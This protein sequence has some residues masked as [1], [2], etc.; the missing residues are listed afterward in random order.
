MVAW[1]ILG[2]LRRLAVPAERERVFSGDYM[3]QKKPPTRPSVIIGLVLLP[4]AWAE[5]SDAQTAYFKGKTIT[6]VQGRDPGGQG[7]MR[8]RALIAVLQKHIPGNPAIVSEYM[9]GG[10]GRKAANHMFR[11]ARPDGFTIANIGEGF[12][13]SAVLGETGVQY[14]ID[15][16]IYLG[17]GSSQ[18]NYVF[19][20][21]SQLGL[22][23]IEKLRAASGVRIGGQTVGHSIYFVG[24]IFGWLME[25]KNPKF[26]PGYSG[27]DLDAALLQG[28]IDARASVPDDITRRGDWLEKGLVHWHALFE[29][30]RGYRVS[31]P[32]FSKI[33][34]L[35]T[36]AKTDRGKKV[37]AMARNFRLIGVPHILPPGTAPEAAE[38][39]KAAFRKSLKDPEFYANMKKLTGG[40]AAPLMPEEQENAI[41]EIPRERET[42]E[43]Y[44]KIA[45]PDPLP[46]L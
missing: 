16:F 44:K 20:T 27:P 36:F 9:D 29:I 17:A 21:R 12:V 10:G 43:A 38:I 45:G 25:L 19:Y 31:H 22:N 6:I 23:A 8:V 41:K 46:P 18:T 1:L 15:K 34:S 33:D 42:I 26:I 30:P 40:E 14:D 24:R 35:D 11:I 5:P 39:L 32:A 13:S 37:L 3:T 28:E 4:F 2:P 7:D